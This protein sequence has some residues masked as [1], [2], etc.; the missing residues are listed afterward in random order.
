MQKR[1]RAIDVNSIRNAWI[2]ASGAMKWFWQRVLEKKFD[3]IDI[4]WMKPQ[5]KCVDLAFCS[6]ILYPPTSTKKTVLSSTYIVRTKL[7]P[8]YMG[9]HSHR[10]TNAHCTHTHKFEP[11]LTI[12]TQKLWICENS[13]GR[14]RKVENSIFRLEIVVEPAVGMCMHCGIIPFHSNDSFMHSDVVNVN[15]FVHCWFFFLQT[16]LTFTKVECSTVHGILA[17]ILY[18]MHLMHTVY[19]NI[20]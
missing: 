18:Y 1:A 13:G 12:A 16:K 15:A 14:G 3:S 2:G 17:Y 5:Q 4:W 8:K 7:K 10:C 11:N 20:L 19:E 6:F 9:S